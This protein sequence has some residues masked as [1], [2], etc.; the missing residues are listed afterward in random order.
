MKIISILNFRLCA[1]ACAL[2]LMSATLVCGQQKSTSKAEMKKPL[3]AESSQGVILKD[4]P[5]KIDAAGR[6]LFYLHGRIIEDKGIRPTSEEYGVYEYEKILQTFADKGFTVISEARP[7]G[8]DVKLYAP[9]V[10]G[11]INALLKKGVPAQ[12][13]TVVGASKG[14]VITMLVSTGLKNRH[15][16]FVIMASCND[17]VLKNHEVDLYGNVLSIYDVKDVYG[18]TCRKFFDRAKGLNRSKEV[19]LKIGT[20]HAILYQPLKEWV[21]LVTEWARPQ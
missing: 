17:S 13:I 6:Y 10:I 1:F 20:G 4:V 19:E 5:E 7:T 16:N 9:K 15:V 14:A 21:D 11:Q 12:S 3:P 2:I 18:Q 8:T